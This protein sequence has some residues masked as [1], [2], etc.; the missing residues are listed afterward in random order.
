MQK[1]TANSRMSQLLREGHQLS[2]R[3]PHLTNRHQRAE[4]AFEYARRK[5]NESKRRP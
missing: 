1:P 5:I 2:F 4:W 3:Q